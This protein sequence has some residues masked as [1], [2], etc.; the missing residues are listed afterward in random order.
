MHDANRGEARNSRAGRTGRAEE[1]IRCVTTRCRPCRPASNR[2]RQTVGCVHGGAVAGHAPPQRGFD[3]PRVPPAAGVAAAWR[4][5]DAPA[6]DTP[7]P[8]SSAD[9]TAGPGTSAHTP[10]GGK[11]ATPAAAPWWTR[12]LRRYAAPVPRERQLPGAARGG[13][14]DPPRA[15]SPS[16]DC[17]SGRPR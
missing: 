13:C 9:S 11:S 10:C 17:F 14:H 8:G 6:V 2:R 1:G 3:A 12:P 15:L 16:P 4:A 7:A 5:N